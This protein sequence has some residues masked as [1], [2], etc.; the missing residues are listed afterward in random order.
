MHPEASLASVK[1]PP[2][3][4]RSARGANQGCQLERV[5]PT[6][7]RAQVLPQ[8]SRRSG[9]APCSSAGKPEWRSGGRGE[10]EA[11]EGTWLSPKLEVRGTL[12]PLGAGPAG[13]VSS[14]PEAS[15]QATCVPASG[16]SPS[17]TRGCAPYLST[18]PVPAGSAAFSL[19]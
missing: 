2:S 19:C 15:P 7:R 14:P 11:E 5:A 17:R 16:R 13:S 3:V 10:G 18:N 9:G 4:T 1:A 6:P 12:L 8:M